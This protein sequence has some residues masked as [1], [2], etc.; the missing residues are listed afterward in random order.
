MHGNNERHETK[1]LIKFTFSGLEYLGERDTQEDFHAFLLEPD[2]STLLLVLADGMGGH[3]SGEVASRLA[4]ERFIGSFQSY[5]SESSSI[6]LAASLERANLELKRFIDSNPASEGMGCT[7]VAVFFDGKGLSWVSVGDSPLF[8]LRKG[9][10]LRLNADHSMAPVIAESVKAGRITREEAER[11]PQR[12]ALRSALTGAD[13]SLIDV[14]DQPLKVRSGDILVSA[15]DG[16]LTLTELEITTVLKRA[17]SHSAEDLVRE[18][19]SEVKR[20]SKPRQDN[21]AIQI[22]AFGNK[23]G[24]SSYM[25]LVF[26][27]LV[28]VTLAMLGL[29]AAKE[30]GFLNASETKV[31]QPV[32]VPIQPAS[33]N[34]PELLVPPKI[35]VTP[36]IGSVIPER[37]ERDSRPKTPKATEKGSVDKALPNQPGARERSGNGVDRTDSGKQDG[38]PKDGPDS[39]AKKDGVTEPDGKGTRDPGMIKVRDRL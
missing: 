31:T 12:N 32:S 23:P 29:Y 22:V 11:H 10:L 38:T 27:L 4:V 7:L 1:P 25:S 37:Q 2:G 9:K 28:I 15:S 19:M 26:G 34:T 5:K 14:S 16:L 20:R 3:V 33:P 24:T 21:T 18:L 35:G 8:L 30:T 13:V 17:A 36:G 6:R 39:G